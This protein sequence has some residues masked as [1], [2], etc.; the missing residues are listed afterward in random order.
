VYTALD[1][2][3]LRGL[4]TKNDV[5]VPLQVFDPPLIS[6]LQVYYVDVE[7]KKPAKKFTSGTQGATRRPVFSHNGDKVAWLQRDKDGKAE[8]CGTIVNSIHMILNRCP[9]K[10]S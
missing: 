9:G 6:L 5:R 3:L 2:A 10:K 4:N 7:R 1:P 8:L